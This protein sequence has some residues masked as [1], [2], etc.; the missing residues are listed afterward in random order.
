MSIVLQAAGPTAVLQDAQWYQSSATCVIES[1][2]YSEKEMG[3][4]G[5]RAHE[6]TASGITLSNRWTVHSGVT[7]PGPHRYERR[8]V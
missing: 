1:K 3:K 2:G 5:W 4:S 8:R 7:G 6:P